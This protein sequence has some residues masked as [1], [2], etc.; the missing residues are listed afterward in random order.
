MLTGA[1]GLKAP[2]TAIF[3]AETK[4]QKPPF[5]PLEIGTETNR[6]AWRKPA[7]LAGHGRVALLNDALLRRLSGAGFRAHSSVGRADDS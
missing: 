4:A 7:R 3:D 1:Q 6:H 5:R 2:G